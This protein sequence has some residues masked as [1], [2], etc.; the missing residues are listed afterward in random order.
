MVYVNTKIIEGNNMYY[1]GHWLFNKNKKILI[2]CP[3]CYGYPAS[4]HMMFFNSFDVSNWDL[5]AWKCETCYK[6]FIT[7]GPLSKYTYA[8]KYKSIN[9]FCSPLWVTD[10]EDVDI[11]IPNVMA[12]K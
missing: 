8:I 3:F 5:T 12:Q 2:H 11:L 7:S 4:R 10:P 9:A 1:I 6:Y